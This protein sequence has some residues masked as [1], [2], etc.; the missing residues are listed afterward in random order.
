MS[1]I[2]IGESM[3]R[4]GRMPTRTQWHV[5]RRL[6]P[7]MQ[8]LMPVL[9][10]SSN[11]QRDLVGDGDGAMTPDLSGVNLF[12]ALGALTDTIGMLSDNDADYILDA[13]LACVMW[14]QGRQWMPI[15]VPGGAFTNGQADEFDV[16][17]RLLWEVLRESLANFSFATVFPSPPTNGL[18]TQTATTPVPSAA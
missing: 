7:V 11:P 1:D 10:R 3:F 13:A 16:Q 8:G 2:Q 17:M 9:L 12:E 15:R 14:R 6:I 18:D 4:C 5:V